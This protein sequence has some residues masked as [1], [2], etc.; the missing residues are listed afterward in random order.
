LR[1]GKEATHGNDAFEAAVEL[2]DVLEDR[3]HA[4]IKGLV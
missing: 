1:K 2:V 4:L 3:F